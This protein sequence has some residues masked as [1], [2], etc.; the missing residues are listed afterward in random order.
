[1]SNELTEAAEPNGWIF[2]FV[3]LDFKVDLY[4]C[5]G[6]SLLKVSRMP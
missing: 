5:Q 6:R 3:L 2:G 1:M 4:L